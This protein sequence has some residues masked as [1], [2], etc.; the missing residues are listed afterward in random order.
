MTHPTGPCVCISFYEE[1]YKY[2]NLVAVCS[3]KWFPMFYDESQALF[4][5]P[6]LDL[7]APHKIFRLHG[8]S[9]NASGISARV[10]AHI[11]YFEY[12]FEGI[13]AGCAGCVRQK[14]R[15]YVLVETRRKQT[16]SF[17]PFIRKAMLKASYLIAGFL[18]GALA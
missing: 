2:R 18:F 3:F 10:F 5:I 13:P 6:P 16:L 4:S 11:L 15:R 8:N 1:P 7:G 14:E 12:N 17:V 9:R